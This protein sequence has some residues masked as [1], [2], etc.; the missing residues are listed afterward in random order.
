M[1]WEDLN[2]LEKGYSLLQT[3]DYGEGAR[4]QVLRYHNKNFLIL[5]LDYNFTSQFPCVC[6]SLLLYERKIDWN[7]MKSD[8]ESANASFPVSVVQQVLLDL[9]V[10]DQLKVSKQA[11]V[12]LIQAD[13]GFN[14]TCCSSLWGKLSTGSLGG[15][16]SSGT[17]YPGEAEEHHTCIPCLSLHLL[18]CSR[19]KTQPNKTQAA[20]RLLLRRTRE[21]VFSEL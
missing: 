15:M 5:T 1:S 11:S 2:C 14:W 10:L 4:M 20:F 7:H 3:A 12:T 19:K 9:H 13:R 18:I 17:S 8:R 21:G 16:G 6:I